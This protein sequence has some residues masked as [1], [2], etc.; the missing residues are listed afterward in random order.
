[1]SDFGTLIDGHTVRFERVFPLSIDQLWAYL[2]SADGLRR[3][4]AEGQIGP[5][6]VKLSFSNNNSSIDGAVTAWA[7]PHLVEFEWNGGPTQPKG[8]RVRFQLTAEPAGTR[9]ILS[10]TAV[11]GPAGPDFSAGW[12]RHLDALSA[13][14][15]GNE[16]A[17]DRPTWE[18]LHQVYRDLPRTQA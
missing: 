15:R 1:M 4:L 18:R 11:V 2:T 5:E 14:A 10:H 17:A 16:P 3:W 6:R 8:S 7:P 9:L 13:H 12:H